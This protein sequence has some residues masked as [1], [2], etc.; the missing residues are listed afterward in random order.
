[1]FCP[2]CGIHVKQ[3]TRFCHSSGRSLELLNDIDETEETCAP[4]T[5]KQPDNAKLTNDHSDT[6]SDSEI[7]ITLRSKAEFNQADTVV[8]EPQ[9][10]STPKH[11]PQE[12]GDAGEHSSTIHPG[13]IVISDTEDLDPSEKNQGKTSCYSKYTEVY[14]PWV[15]EEE[16]EL[17]SGSV[18]NVQHAAVEETD[19][20]LPDIIANL[21]HPIDHGRVCRFN[22]SRANVWDGA[23]RGF[24]RTKYSETFDM[25]VKF[26]DDAGVFE[27]GI[28]TG[29]PRREFLTL[30]MRH[31]KDRPIFDGPE[32]H[33][34]LVYKAN[35]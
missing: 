6:D 13:Q 28:D 27:E 9:S 29:G 12:K 4:G 2:F 19:I 30:L 23:V 20:T 18:N 14:A 8:F 31:L 16:E 24:R 15:E 33:R 21:S 10:E 34:Y 17:V 25:L 32:G 26:S 35:D 22:I 1:M 5:S 3:K 7:V 11:K